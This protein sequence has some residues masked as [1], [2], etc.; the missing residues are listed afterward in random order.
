MARALQGVGSSCSSVSGKFFLGGVV[1]GL[2][3]CTL[4]VIRMIPVADVINTRTASQS[5]T[6]AFYTTPVLFPDLLVLV[7]GRTKG[8]RVPKGIVKHQFRFVRMK[9]PSWHGINV[10]N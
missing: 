1:G 10:S 4:R 3:N 6:R 8:E 7:Y 9:D 5:T 2:H